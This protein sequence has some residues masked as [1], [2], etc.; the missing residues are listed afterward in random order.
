MKDLSHII[1]KC[2]NQDRLAQ[3]QLYEYCYSRLSTAVALY[4]KDETEKDWIF[5]IGMLKIFKSLEKYQINSNFL[6]WARTILTRTAIDIYRK[7]KKHTE[8]LVPI[9]NE[10]NNNQ[11]TEVN[12]ALNA[13]ETD[14]IIK[15]I[16]G[17]S[18]DERMIF[19][20]YE[21]EGYS[22]VDIE[23]ET[24]V[25]KNTSKWLLAKAK[26]S[27]RETIINSPSLN[28]YLYGK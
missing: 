20:M 5:N 14:E 17:L 10:E 8:W 9:Q 7:Q 3:Q 11:L 4:T 2:I 15:L 12:S 21:I 25:N 18:H 13:L 19:T 24:G 27:L 1:L 26:K 16:Q 28:H 6:G 23:K 22:H